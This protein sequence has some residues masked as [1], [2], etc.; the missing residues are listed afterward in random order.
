[1]GMLQGPAYN[2]TFMMD[3]SKRFSEADLVTVKTTIT[4]HHGKALLL[5]QRNN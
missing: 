2:L 1:M 4:H 3:F 5:V